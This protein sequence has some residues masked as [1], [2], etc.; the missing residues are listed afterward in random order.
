[1]VYSHLFY[2]YRV[3]MKIFMTAQVYHFYFDICEKKVICIQTLKY[4]TE[5]V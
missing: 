3:L 5:T 1:M 4:I 2:C